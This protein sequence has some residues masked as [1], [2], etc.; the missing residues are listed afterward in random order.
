MGKMVSMLIVMLL[1]SHS[2]MSDSLTPHGL[3]HARL[4]CPSPSPGICSNSCPLRQWAIQQTTS[5]VSFSCCLQSFS[6]SGSFDIKWPNHWSFSFSISPSNEYP[7]L[8]SLGPTGLISLQSRD[9]QESTPAPQFQSISS[10]V[11]C[12][13]YASA[14]TTICD[15]WKG[16]MDLCRQ[17]NISAF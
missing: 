5:V 15:Y 12:L 11:L 10:L 6:A 1:F 3:Q 13:L 16:Y 8:I 4:P 14:L 7:G 2:V 9:S 17:S